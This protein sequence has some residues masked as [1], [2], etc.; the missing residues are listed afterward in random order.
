MLLQ[1][2][3]GDQKPSFV[4]TWKVLRTMVRNVKL[5]EIWSCPLEIAYKF[6]TWPQRK[7][8]VHQKFKQNYNFRVT[9]RTVR[10]VL[11]SCENFKFA[12]LSSKPPLAIEH[13]QAWLEF[14]KLHMASKE[15]CQTVIFSDE[16]NF[17]LDGADGIQHYWHD[18]RKSPTCSLKAHPRWRFGNGLGSI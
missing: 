18:L 3:L 17:N 4:I 5:K 16:N 13:K 10:R 1:K 9:S 6:S 11:S 8:P 7:R 14:A 2:L 12:K 15:F